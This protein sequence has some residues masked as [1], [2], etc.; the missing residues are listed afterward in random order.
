MKKLKDFEVNNKKQ[1]CY[2]CEKTVSDIG[3]IRVSTY[4]PSRT[5]I[6]GMKI[7]S[8][9]VIHVCGKCFNSISQKIKNLIVGK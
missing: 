4:H 9:Y 7:Q 3:I 2:A 5:Y 1:V 8:N 6:S